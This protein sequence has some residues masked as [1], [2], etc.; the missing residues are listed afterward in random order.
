MTIIIV[1]PALIGHYVGFA[2]SLH[3][4]QSLRLCT[5]RIE[6]LAQYDFLHDSNG[7][8]NPK[9]GIVH[10]PKIRPLV[11]LYYVLAKRLLDLE[12]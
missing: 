9:V 3:R 12:Q 5:I 8:L 2:D 11:Q 10:S 7:H 6:G 4:E 1:L